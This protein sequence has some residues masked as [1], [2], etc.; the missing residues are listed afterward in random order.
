METDEEAVCNDHKQCDD[1]VVQLLLIPS[2]VL[3]ILSLGP[4]SPCEA[5]LMGEEEERKTTGHVTEA[6]GTP[7]E[8]NPELGV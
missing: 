7:V 2:L 5:H 8:L 3:L 1:G 4:P 6:P